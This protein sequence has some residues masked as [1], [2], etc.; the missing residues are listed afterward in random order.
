MVPRIN[1][2]YCITTHYI[3]SFIYSPVF[4]PNNVHSVIYVQLEQKI[5]DK[6]LAIQT[7]ASETLIISY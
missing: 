1:H 6:L 5:S 2:N 4:L 7:I 3:Q